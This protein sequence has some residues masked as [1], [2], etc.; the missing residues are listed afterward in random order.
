MDRLL[1]FLAFEGIT[2]TPEARQ[3]LLWG[4]AYVSSYPLGRFHR[5]LVTSV[6]GGS[7]YTQGL[8]DHD[9]VAVR[10]FD[11]ESPTWLYEVALRAQPWLRAMLG[12]GWRSMPIAKDLTRELSERDPKKLSAASTSAVL[13]QLSTALGESLHDCRL[14]MITEFLVPP[15]VVG[16]GPAATV[17]QLDTASASGSRDKSST[18][19]L[20][21]QFPTPD[22]S[23]WADVTIRFTSDLQVQITVRHSTEVRTYAEMGVTR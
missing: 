13:E 3:H 5:W 12:A 23:I 1:Q 8:G 9:A 14:K 7:S 21:K 11:W 6:E 4:T 17:R 18:G 19:S 22:G 2:S 16:T 20:V 15:M 10:W